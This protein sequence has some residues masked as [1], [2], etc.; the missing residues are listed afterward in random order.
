MRTVRKNLNIFRGDTRTI[1]I[2]ITDSDKDAF[3]LTGYI[4]TF[5]A[6]SGI[7]E[8]ISTEQACTTAPTTG[9]ESIVLSSE[10]TDVAI[11]TYYFDIQV[12]NTDD[13][14]IVYTVMIGRLMIER[15][16]TT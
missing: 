16:I 15:D 4:A 10:D 1:V 13:P 14:P 2:T 8:M 6:K 11:G 12:E 7:T 5:T 3:D 9:I